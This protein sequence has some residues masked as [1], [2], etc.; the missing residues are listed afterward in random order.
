M[1]GMGGRQFAWG[2]T[3][4]S[5]QTSA[6]GLIVPID[7]T[8]VSWAFALARNINREGTKQIK[9]HWTSARARATRVES[10]FRCDPGRMPEMRVVTF[11]SPERFLIGLPFTSSSGLTCPRDSVE[12]GSRSWLSSIHR[13][14]WA[15]ILRGHG[16]LS[17][18]QTSKVAW[19]PSCVRPVGRRS[20]RGDQVSAKPPALHASTPTISQTLAQFAGN[21][22]ST[23]ANR[24]A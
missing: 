12:Y 24:R 23:P 7:H 20:S 2:Q 16:L 8:W 15:L 1:V 5:K 18:A 6:R 4:R 22:S 13:R 9:T 21:D 17:R 19:H 3:V 11:C 14:A 10:N